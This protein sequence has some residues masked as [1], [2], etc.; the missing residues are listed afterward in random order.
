MKRWDLSNLARH[1]PQTA[2]LRLRF[3]PARCCAPA[4][5]TFGEKREDNDLV[6]IESVEAGRAA[7]EF[8]MRDILAAKSCLLV[9]NCMQGAFPAFPISAYR[10][11]TMGGGGSQIFSKF[12]ISH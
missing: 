7:S 6:V 1:P 5:R 3:D 11:L 2:G 8:S 4:R 10:M 12:V 9:R